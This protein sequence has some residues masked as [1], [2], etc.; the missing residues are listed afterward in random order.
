[1]AKPN[2][3]LAWYRRLTAQKFDDSK[4]RRYPRRPRI[5]PKLEALIAQMA[6]E[7]SGRG[8]DRIVG[9]LSNL[10]YTVSDETGSACFELDVVGQPA[11][12][13]SLCRWTCA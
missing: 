7:N 2:T 5:E 13:L 8:Y 12:G 11:R 9:A 3:I 4:H 6:K 10:G 1:V